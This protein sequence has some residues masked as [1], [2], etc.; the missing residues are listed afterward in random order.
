M[1]NGHL[2]YKD[3]LW[4]PCGAGWQESVVHVN[5]GEHVP[6]PGTTKRYLSGPGV[7][8]YRQAP[9]GGYQHEVLEGMT[10][11]QVR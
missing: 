3:F 5:E 8:K 11:G 6:L 7:V 2:S 10:E 1:V 9:D 4:T